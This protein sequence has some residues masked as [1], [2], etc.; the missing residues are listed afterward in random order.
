M[1]CTKYQDPIYGTDNRG[2]DLR[3][4]APTALHSWGSALRACPCGCRKHPLSEH[5]LVQHGLRGFS[6]P[7]TL[8]GQ[9]RFIHPKEAGLLNTWPASI[10]LPSPARGALVLIGQIAAP[11]QAVWVFSHITNWIAEIH[12]GHAPRSPINYVQEYQTKLL[13]DRDLIFA[14][15]HHFCPRTIRLRQHNE[16]D[17]H[18]NP[19]DNYSKPRPSCKAGQ[20]RSTS[21]TKASSERRMS[22]CSQHRMTPTKSIAPRRSKHSIRPQGTSVSSSFTRPVAKPTT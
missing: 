11:L 20:P 8:Q 4:P 14:T 6:V 13:V 2:L 22:Y 18:I 16:P 17:V 1:R 7:S 21:D 3:A 10:P 15:R 5:R 19:S 9:P 12:I